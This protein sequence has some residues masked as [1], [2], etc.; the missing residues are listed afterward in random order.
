MIGSKYFSTFEWTPRVYF[1][2]WAKRSAR[3]AG[4]RG[5]LCGQWSCSGCTQAMMSCSPH[6]SCHHHLP[7]SALSQWWARV[8]GIMRSNLLPVATQDTLDILTLRNWPLFRYVIVLSPGF[9]RSDLE[10][11]RVYSKLFLEYN[12][13]HRPLI[14]PLGSFPYA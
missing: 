10:A 2:I 5:C 9:C 13:S 1:S 7:P 6:P 14:H 3:S 12:K 11:S 4:E 8:P